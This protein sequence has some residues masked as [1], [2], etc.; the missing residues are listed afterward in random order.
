M[1]D[2]YIGPG[3]EDPGR[4]RKRHRII[5]AATELFRTQGYRKTSVDQVAEGAGV[6]KGTVY[7]YFQTKA[8][9]LVA[10]IAREKRMYLARFRSVFEDALEPRERLKRWLQGV[11]VSATEMPLVSRLVA[12][13]RE[14]AVVQSELPPELMNQS[15]S[16]RMEI[17]GEMIEEAAGETGWNRI[18]LEDRVKVLVSLA[19]MAG[20]ASQ[21]DVRGG[22]S[23]ERYST[24]LAEMVVDGLGAKNPGASA[25]SKAAGGSR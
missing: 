9:L 24:I 19:Y 5:D 3:D 1:L 20:P 23:M 15:D 16:M 6:A 17:L 8:E 25:T 13:P 4:A 2:A 22:L 7:L 10:A 21:P 18:E 14:L 12:D 11:L